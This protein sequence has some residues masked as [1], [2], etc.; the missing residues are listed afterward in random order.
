MFQVMRKKT[1]R[2]SGMSL[3][4]II[5]VLFL[6]GLI[7]GLLFTLLEKGSFIFKRAEKNVESQQNALMAVIALDSYMRESVWKSVAFKES[8]DNYL[9]YKNF[10]LNRIVDVKAVSFIT[11]KDSD[12]VFRYDDLTGLPMWQRFVIFF[13]GD[14]DIVNGVKRHTLYMKTYTPAEAKLPSPVPT[15]LNETNL[16][17]GLSY[18]SSSTKTIARNIVRIE[19]SEPSLNQI[20]FTVVSSVELKKDMRYEETYISQRVLFRN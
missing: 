10:P 18:A 4:E 8:N 2:R 13:L 5:I 19:F 15:F 16:N 6:W 20:C 1:I 11:A 7:L 3:A 9:N 17:N 14:Q 12:N